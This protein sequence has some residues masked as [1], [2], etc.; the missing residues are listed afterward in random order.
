[1]VSKMFPR[2]S[3]A[4]HLFFAFLFA[5]IN[6]WLVRHI[7]SLAGLDPNSNEWSWEQKRK[8]FFYLSLFLS[9]PAFLLYKTCVNI[10]YLL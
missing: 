8:R 7:L 5:F 9:R 6:I 10:Q 1:M 3:I 2:K 4:F